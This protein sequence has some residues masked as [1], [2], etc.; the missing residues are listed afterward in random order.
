MCAVVRSSS[1]A[2]RVSWRRLFKW[3]RLVVVPFVIAC[4]G[5]GASS[6]R[7]AVPPRQDPFYTYSGSTPLA[8]IAPGTV[9]KTRVL[10]YHVI[11]IALPI[12]TVQLLYRSTGMGGQSTVNATS[13]LEPPRSLGPPTIVSYQSFYDSLNPDDEPSYAISGGVTLGGLIPNVES[14]LIVPS[15]LAGHA[16]VVPDTEGENADFAAGPEYGYNTLDSLRAALSSPVTELS[17]TRK[18]GLAGYSGGA[19]A[20]EWAAELAPSYAPDIN[21]RLVGAAMGGVLVDPDHNLHYLNGSSFWAGVM[22]MAIIGVTRAFHVDITPYLS[23]TG[24]QL[25]HKLRTASIINVLGRYPGLTWAQLTTPGHQTPESIPLFVTIAN[26]LI[27]GSHGTPAVPLL[28]DQGADGAV[29]GTPPSPAFGRGDGVMV[30][31]DVRALADEYCARGVAVQYSQY[32]S[33]EHIGTGVA[34]IADTAS[35]LASRFAGTPAPQDCG[36]IAPGNAL[37][38]I[39]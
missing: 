2:A 23:A 29:L 24:R 19:I 32:D 10:S 30:A 21:R 38:R 25:Y 11:G 5:V 4:A 18:I 15:L 14:V 17:H 12:R 1:F 9:L 13:V 16:V 37:A 22:P 28:I 31:G 3:G 6:A 35:W 27:M 39:R 20:T 33:L 8:D 34:W 36:Q 26:Q 7:A